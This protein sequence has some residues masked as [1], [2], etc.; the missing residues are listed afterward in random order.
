VD[1]IEK[2]FKDQVQLDA[3]H[4]AMHRDAQVRGQ[5][6]R[7]ADIKERLQRLA[8]RE[9]EILDPIVAGRRNRAIAADLGISQSTVEAHRARVMDEA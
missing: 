6:M 9:R 4:R 1:F 5:A 3:V 7:L 2:P 8:P